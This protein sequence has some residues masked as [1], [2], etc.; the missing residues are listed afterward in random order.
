MTS[1]AAALARAFGYPY[2]RPDTSFVFAAGRA[3][4]ILGSPSLSELRRPLPAVRL[5]APVGVAAGG[6]AAPPVEGGQEDDAQGETNGPTV[7]RGGGGGLL[8]DL[9]PLR[10]G[11]PPPGDTPPPTA[12]AAGGAASGGSPALQA[13]E[14]IHEPWHTRVAVLG[15]GSN[16]APVQL[17]RKYGP[18][19]AVLPVL[20]ARLSGV[21]VAY[22]PVVAAYG[23]IPATIIGAAAADAPPVAV[24]LTLLTH[25]QLVAMNATET[26]YGLGVVPPGAV[27]LVDVGGGSGGVPLDTPCLAYVQQGGALTRGV[28]GGGPLLVAEMMGAGGEDALTQRQVQRLVAGLVA[29]AA[30]RGGAAAGVAPAIA[31]DPGHSHPTARGTAAAAA[32]GAAAAAAAGVAAAA[33]AVAADEALDAWVLSIIAGG[34]GREAALAAVR[35]AAAPRVPIP[36]HEAIEDAEAAAVIAA[37]APR[38]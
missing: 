29:A 7:A 26:S 38:Q 3:W 37:W 4:P 17:A 1:P 15:I 31:G 32:A 28:G 23:S 19:A 14:V 16:G 30:K 13:G 5:G 24:A 34:C 11:T 10:S 25:A 22:A 9:F 27:S 8:G 6:T 33:D 18:A 2:P 12:S 36:G 20:R 21:V 35:A